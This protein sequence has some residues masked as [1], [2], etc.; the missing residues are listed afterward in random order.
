M[1]DTLAEVDRG[2]VNAEERIES[3]RI[4]AEREVAAARLERD[5]K[6][7]DAAAE[8]VRRA[9]SDLAAANA[10]L[11]AAI[12]PE[13]AP[14]FTNRTMHG[15]RNGA[16][17]ERVSAY[18][19]GHMLATA[20]PLLDIAE[21]GRQEKFGS[22]SAKPIEATDGETPARSLLTDGASDPNARRSSRDSLLNRGPIPQCHGYRCRRRVDCRCTILA[23]IVHAVR[24]CAQAG[25]IVVRVIPVHPILEQSSCSLVVALEVSC[26]L[27]RRH[28]QPPVLGLRSILAHPFIAAA[29]R[30]ELV[31]LGPEPLEN[32]HTDTAAHS[33][34]SDFSLCLPRSAACRRGAQSA[35]R[36]GAVSCINETGP[37]MGRRVARSPKARGTLGMPD[38]YGWSGSPVFLAPAAEF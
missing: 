6:A 36:S 24:P 13:S 3:D 29:R 28:I 4:L 19:T 17:P 22:V 23:V 30:Q 27:S 14:L 11:T 2:V 10:A 25:M 1:A 26:P 32:G 8:R 21:A 15:M 38:G 31:Q 35:A 18:L 7:I 33:R 20:M 37:P 9:V 16:P 34:R 12:T 5:S